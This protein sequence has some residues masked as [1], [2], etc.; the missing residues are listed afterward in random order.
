MGPQCAVSDCPLSL[1]H[2]DLLVCKMT[3]HKKC[4]HKIQTYCSY[5]SGKKIEPGTEPGHFGVCVDS[6]TSD[7]VSVPVVLEKLLEHVEMHGLYTEGLYRKS[8]AANRT[9]ELRQALQTDPTAVKLENFPIHAIT[10]VLK[11]WLRELPEP[12][13]TFAQY[14]DFLRA[15]A[16]GSPAPWGLS[17]EGRRELTPRTLL[18]LPE[19]QEQLA[20]IYAVLEHLPE[21]NHNSL[22]RLIFHLVKQVPALLL[23]RSLGGGVPARAP[24]TAFPG[25]AFSGGSTPGCEP[26][27][28]GPEGGPRLLRGTSPPCK[29]ERFSPHGCGST[30]PGSGLWSWGSLWLPPNCGSLHRVALLEDVNRMSPSALAIIFAPCLLR[31]PDNS[32]PLTS[33]KDVLKITT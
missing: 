31:C 22:E 27:L 25:L 1:P 16:G 13:M 18:E 23:P 4:V 30:F 17:G 8:G 28:G 14:G 2:H 24:T 9:R 6:L 7:K 11:Q 12:L 15:V 21:A 10:G 20:A 33:M 3:C 5:T 26:I 29:S 19:K 32:D